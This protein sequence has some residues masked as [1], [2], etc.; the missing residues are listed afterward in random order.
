MEVYVHVYHLEE[1]MKL[2]IKINNFYLLIMG[3]SFFWNSVAM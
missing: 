1:N 3:D 2:P